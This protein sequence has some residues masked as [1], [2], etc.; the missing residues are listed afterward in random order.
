MMAG[1]TWMGCSAGRGTRL[2]PRTPRLGDA[3]ADAAEYSRIAAAPVAGAAQQERSI[4][5]APFPYFGGKRTV[6]AE[7]WRRFG[8]PKQYIE[9]FCGSCAVLLHAPRIAHLEVVNDMNGYIVNFWRAVKHQP[10]AVADAANY[11]VSHLDLG[12]RHAWLTDQART[13]NLAASL[14]DPNW[15]GDAKMAGWWVWGQCSWIGSGWCDWFRARQIPHAGNAG[16][17][18]QAGGQI[19]HAGA[20]RGIQAAGQIPHVGD[21]GMGIQAAGQIPHAGDAGRGWLLALAERLARVRIVHGD[22]QRCLNHHYGQGNTAVF[23]DPPY[24][25]TALLYGCQAVGKEVEQWC[26]VNGHLRVALCGLDGE[27]GLPGWERYAW[28]RNRLTYSSA[29]TR[30]KEVIW[31]S[32]GC[33]TA[34]AGRGDAATLTALPASSGASAVGR[35]MWGSGGASTSRAQHPGRRRQTA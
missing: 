14:A 3:A 20:G 30:A 26:L 34:T 28:T 25:G 13:Q 18:I 9:P 7:I 4:L 8:M 1:R 2:A 17:G 22:W 5:Q 6:A 32:P 21:A 11:P 27:Y 29:R 31:F 12:A 35:S 24:R 23:L 33:L 19:P 16:R 15:P 10:D